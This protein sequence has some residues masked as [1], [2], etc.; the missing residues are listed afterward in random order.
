[1]GQSFFKPV[2]KFVS[3]NT[4]IE[5]LKLKPKSFDRLC[6]LNGIYPVVSDSKHSYDVQDGWYYKIDDVKKLYYSNGYN[7]LNQNFKKELKRAKFIKGENVERVNRI[8]DEEMNFVEIVKSKFPS[9][10][11]SLEDLGN[12][13]K[14][15]YLIKVLD[16][17][18]DKWDAKK[19]L[20]SFEN[21]LIDRGL[22]SAAFLSKKGMYFSFNCEK[23]I[24]MWFVPYPGYNL[25]DFVEEKQDIP[26]KRKNID[27]DFMEFG[28][29]TDG[30][31]DSSQDLDVNDDSKMDISLL[32]YGLPLYCMH[33]NLCIFKL[34]K[35]LSNH[36]KNTFFE[37]I[38][39]HI[40]TKSIYDQIRLVIEC[41]G[42]IIEDYDNAEII[43]T[44]VVT[45]ANYKKSYVQ[46][47]YIFDCLNQS[48][49]LIV[50]DYIV[51]KTC[52]AHK[53]PFPNVMDIIDDRAIRILSNRK[54]YDILDRIEDLN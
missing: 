47:Q 23:I 17:D 10:G 22:I 3:R 8:V 29:F 28:N 12:S 14:N 26:E 50:D 7:V 13:I 25:A 16:I 32:K 51:G 33:L 2:K 44:E 42:G 39:F 37:N 21:F 48:K 1:M 35:I 54:K 31:S 49:K 53:S 27:L 38:T 46:P 52:P 19:Y 4:A 20:T 40:V 34:E 6:V 45:D 30:E 41:C 36:K 15:L 11:S 43:I 5:R 18:N 24:I 9:F